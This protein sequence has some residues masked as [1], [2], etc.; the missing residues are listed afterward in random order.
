MT[1]WELMIAVGLQI[2]W[3]YCMVYLDFELPKTWGLG[4][5]LELSKNKFSKRQSMVI[6]SLIKGYACNVHSVTSAACC[7]SKQMLN[8]Q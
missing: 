2:S 4:S 8:P 6:A 5:E 1:C 3:G 7:W